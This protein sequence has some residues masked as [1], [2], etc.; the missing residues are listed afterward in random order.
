M[1]QALIRYAAAAIKAERAP[2]AD[3]GAF[4]DLRNRKFSQLVRAKLR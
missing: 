3:L 2:L 4:T 1:P